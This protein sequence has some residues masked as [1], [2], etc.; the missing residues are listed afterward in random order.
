V[1]ASRADIAGRTAVQFEP[2]APPRHA[3]P[4]TPAARSGQRRLMDLAHPESPR[5]GLPEI[6]I[7]AG[8]RVIAKATATK[9]RRDIAPWL[10]LV[11]VPTEPMARPSGA[12]L[13]QIE[14]AQQI[15]IKTASLAESCEIRGVGPPVEP[16]NGGTGRQE[17]VQRRRRYCSGHAIAAG[18]P[19]DPF[20]V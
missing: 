4:A 5:P 6:G 7:A 20:P 19:V 15:W 9:S 12:D 11:S 17:R 13:C 18:C 14:L 16:T 10:G 3:L 8:G 1:T 2:P